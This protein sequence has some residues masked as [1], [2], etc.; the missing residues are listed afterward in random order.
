MC[1]HQF[2]LKLFLLVCS[3]SVCLCVVVCPVHLRVIVVNVPE[4]GLLLVLNGGLYVVHVIAKY[5]F[6][7]VGVCVAVFLGFVEYVVNSV[8]VPCF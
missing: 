8:V 1:T 5:V 7:V 3:H 4:F 6:V 2:P